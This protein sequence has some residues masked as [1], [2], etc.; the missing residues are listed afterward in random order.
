MENPENIL[1]F[2]ANVK[3]RLTT[4]QQDPEHLAMGSVASIQYLGS[5]PDVVSPSPPLTPLPQSYL[6]LPSWSC[7]IQGWL[8]LIFN[9]AMCDSKPA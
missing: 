3:C 1:E 4:K 7:V 8:L 6:Q 5:H 2:I 9:F